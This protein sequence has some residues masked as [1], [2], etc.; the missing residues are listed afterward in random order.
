MR[1]TLG[2]IR[3]LVI[4]VVA[5]AALAAG[6]ASAPGA[7]GPS[8]F[9]LGARA[10]WTLAD[11]NGSELKIRSTRSSPAYVLHGFPGF[12]ALR[13]RAAGRDVQAW[14]ARAGW[15]QFLRLGAAAGARYRVDLAA[16]PFWRAVDVTVSRASCHVGT[17]IVRGCVTLEVRALEPI[18]DAGV[19]RL[20]FA[21][22]I[23]PV[24][25]VVQTIAGPRS[26]ALRK[27]GP[28]SP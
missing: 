21:P 10:T 20:V 12:A 1:G 24:E 22:G 26:Y 19:E 8:L 16:S 5:L 25:V 17:R 9:P 7:A 14:D 27:T 18:A 15:K 28:S 2:G 23:G 11:E 6:P 3:G 13:V 4:T